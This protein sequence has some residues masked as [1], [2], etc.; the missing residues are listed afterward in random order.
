MSRVER[1]RLDTK[2]W[3]LQ[4]ERE[5]LVRSLEDAA[6]EHGAGD[7]SDEDYALLRARDERRL[8]EVD[9]ALSATSG[10]DPGPLRASRRVGGLGEPTIATDGRRS[11][12]LVLRRRLQWRR[13]WWMA[14]VGTVAVA[15]ATVLLVAELSSPRLPGEDATGSIALNTAQ[16]I[17]QRLSQADSLAAAGKTAEAL[18]LYG[19]VLA[20]DPRQPVALAEWGWLDWRAATRAKAQAIAAEGASAL[21][22]AVKV[23]P[24]LYAAQYYLGVVLYEEGA[25]QKAVS[26]FAKFLADK[27]SAAWLHEAAPEL[28]AAYGAVHEPVPA[29]VPGG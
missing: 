1:V 10:A 24:R 22:E 12:R 14:L 9:A 2:S 20:E 29:P 7:L 17:E 6:R 19:D 28:R 8:V 11:V 26:H 23:D 15:A 21:E 13:R 5:L 27:P 25:R 16:Q 18:Q 4:D 3:H